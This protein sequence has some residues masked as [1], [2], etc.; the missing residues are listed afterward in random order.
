MRLVNC[1]VDR[2]T[3][4]IGRPSP[5]GNP[6][7]MGHHGNRDQVIR[8]FESYARK[9]PEIIAE[10][11]KLPQDAVLGCFCYPKA[12][13]GDAIIKLWNEIHVP[14]IRRLDERS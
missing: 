3:H 2:Y 7:R 4:Y 8:M 14:I 11:R 9:H 5:L 13:H 12:C 6:F 10:I 1:K